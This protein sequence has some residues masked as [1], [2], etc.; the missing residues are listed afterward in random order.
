MTSE[1]VAPM[2]AVTL[3]IRVMGKDRVLDAPGIED[4]LECAVD[5]I[6]SGQAIPKGVFLEGVEV[7]S[8]QDINTYWEQSSVQ[9]RQSGN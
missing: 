6:S 4:A 1:A 3:K 7:C 8:E 5:L 2:S 9:K